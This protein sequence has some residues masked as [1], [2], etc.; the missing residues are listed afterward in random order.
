[1]CDSD[2]RR[3][4][5]HS[6]VSQLSAGELGHSLHFPSA[7]RMCTRGC[8]WASGVWRAAMLPCC[9]AG[10]GKWGHQTPARLAF[11]RGRSLNL[12]QRYARWVHHLTQGAWL[13]PV[14]R[15]AVSWSQHQLWLMQ[16]N[17]NPNEIVVGP[18]PDVSPVLAVS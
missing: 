5:V 12:T 6:V 13:Q 15:A 3:S 2:E 16:A 14:Q 11:H 1:M 17:A 4:A 9:H 10:W 7:R 18:S 8:M